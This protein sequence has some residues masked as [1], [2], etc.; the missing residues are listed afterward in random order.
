MWRIRFHYSTWVREF[1]LYNAKMLKILQVVDRKF[2][3]RNLDPKAITESYFGATLRETAPE[4]TAL[5]SLCESQSLI[6]ELYESRIASMQRFVAMTVMFHE[7][8]RRVH[9]FFPRVS[10]DYL[11]DR[12]DRTHS[13]IM[14][15]ATTASPVSGSDVRERIDTIKLKYSITKA[16]WYMYCQQESQRLLREK[17]TKEIVEMPKEE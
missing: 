1:S 9:R 10:F 13:S 12:I 2:T 4:G 17:S 7:M 5:F 14:R 15:I 16:A 3:A 6:M 11:G 8:R